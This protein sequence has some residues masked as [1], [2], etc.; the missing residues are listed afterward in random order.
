MPTDLRTEFPFYDENR[1][2]AMPGYEL[3][4]TDG[5]VEAWEAER[6][7][8][9]AEVY[10]EDVAEALRFVVNWML[11]CKTASTIG[12]RAL[13]LG[14]LI[15]I[16]HGLNKSFAQIADAAGCSREAVRQAARQLEDFAGMRTQLNRTD[17]N[18]KSCKRARLKALSKAV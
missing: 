3:R 2:P 18:R 5:A 12:G 4:D 13:L 7:E 17:T 11:G 8:E 16:D 6:R 1:M 9:P 14:Q 10:R 15:G